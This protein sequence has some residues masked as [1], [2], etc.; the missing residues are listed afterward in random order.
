MVIA[1]KE[2]LEGKK[3][4]YLERYDITWQGVVYIAVMFGFPLILGFIFLPELA[5]A[6]YSQNINIDIMAIA[7]LLF[8]FMDLLDLDLKYPLLKPLEGKGDNF[9]IAIRNAGLIIPL[10]L[11]TGASISIIYNI[12]TWNFYLGLFAT[13]AFVACMII[14]ITKYKFEKKNPNKEYPAKSQ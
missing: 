9:Q 3:G 5:V 1:K 11:I 13:T 4:S 6:G 7:W 8:S 10:L 14:A 12:H 2:W